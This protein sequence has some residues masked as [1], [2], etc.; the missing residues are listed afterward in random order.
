MKDG[1]AVGVDDTK[2]LQGWYFA[3]IGEIKHGMK[4]L[5]NSRRRWNTNSKSTK[6]FNAEY[7]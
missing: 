1:K 2:T 6:D 4:T 7:I 3:G 5:L